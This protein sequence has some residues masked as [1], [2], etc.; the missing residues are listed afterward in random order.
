MSKV[1]IYFSLI[2]SYV[3]TYTCSLSFTVSDI[4]LGKNEQKEI[5]ESVEMLQIYEYCMINLHLIL[6]I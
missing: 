3:P 1:T 2:M 5:C 4:G 6:S